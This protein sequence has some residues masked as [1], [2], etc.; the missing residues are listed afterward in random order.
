[1]VVGQRRNR[2][3]VPIDEREREEFLKPPRMESNRP[4][5]VELGLW[6]SCEVLFSHGDRINQQVL[7][8]RKLEDREHHIP[9]VVNDE[10]TTPVNTVGVG[11][12]CCG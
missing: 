4:Q 12:R 7:S 5:L 9:L 6:T 3:D 8:V 11:I 2:D 10:N 1:M